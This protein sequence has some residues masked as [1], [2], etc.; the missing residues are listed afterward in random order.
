MH[1]YTYA[2]AYICPCIH[3]YVCKSCIYV[4]KG[5][6]GGYTIEMMPHAY[7]YI[8]THIHMYMYIHKYV[9]MCIHTDT[10]GVWTG[11]EGGAVR[12]AHS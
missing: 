12:A 3:T 10:V 11:D 8:C 7:V 9:Y 1:I 2:H 4:H 5:A 6:V